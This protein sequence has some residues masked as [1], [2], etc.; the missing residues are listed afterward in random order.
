MTDQPRPIRPVPAP[1]R[2]THAYVTRFG[3]TN[4]A[5]VL[6]AMAQ[7]C[8]QHHGITILAIN[9][10]YTAPEKGPATGFNDDITV[11]L[12]YENTFE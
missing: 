8:L 6:Q 5:D 12:A 1:G 4:E 11:Y 3:G 10:T 9:W 7:W 2:V